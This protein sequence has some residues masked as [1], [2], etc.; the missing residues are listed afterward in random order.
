MSNFWGFISRIIE[1]VTGLV[2]EYIEDADK[3]AEF[4][5]KLRLALMQQESSF[6][7]ASRDI[8]VA[9][10]QGESWLQRNWRPVTM[11]S[12]VAIIVNNYILVPWLLA[13][14]V[15]TVAVLEIPDGM[16]G[17]LTVGLGGYVVG[18]TLEKTG[19][20][21]NINVGQNQSE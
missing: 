8:V 5:T 2:S 15:E 17:L 10:A 18:R 4:E 19:S 20:G 9:E 3:R 11:L 14:G 1:P 16:W 12:F 7:E 6:V 13:L 21:V